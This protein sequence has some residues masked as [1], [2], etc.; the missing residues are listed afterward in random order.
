MSKPPKFKFTTA[1]MPQG[2][3]TKGTRESDSTKI[4]KEQT[5]SQE[6]EST[7]IPEKGTGSRKVPLQKQIKNHFQ[8][9]GFNWILGIALILLPIYGAFMCDSR[10]EWNKSNS[11]IRLLKDKTEKNA[12]TIEKLDAKIESNE[13]RIQNQEVNQAKNSVYIETLREDKE[14]KKKTE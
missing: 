2:T 3:P 11:E 13:E 5:P 12:E 9:H 7:D 1:S 4:E 10:I 14:A 6:E 8:K